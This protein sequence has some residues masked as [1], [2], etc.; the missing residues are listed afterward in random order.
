[1]KKIFK[2]ILT[3]ALVLTMIITIAPVT[4]MQ[5]V[6]AATTSSGR[7]IKNSTGWWYCNPNGSWPAN[8]WANINGK[9]YHFNSKGYMTTGWLK[10]GSKWYYLH[11]GNDGS[12]ATGWIKNGGKWY[13]LKGGNDGSMTTGWLQD[14]NKWY[15]LSGGNDGSMVANGWVKWNGKEYYL[16]GSGAMA[17][18]KWIGQWYVGTDGAWQPNKL[19]PIYGDDLTKPNMVDDK[20]KP[21]YE[22]YTRVVDD[23]TKPITKTEIRWGDDLTKPKYK[24]VPTQ[25][26]SDT[27][28]EYTYGSGSGI[29]CRDCNTIIRSDHPNVLPEFNLGTSNHYDTTGH[30][31]TSSG[32]F[33]NLI[34]I[35]KTPKMVT[36]IEH[37]QDGYEQ[38]AEQYEVITGYAQKVE[39][40]QKLVGYEQKHDGT[41]Q[42][43]IIGY[44]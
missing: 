18:D 44:K 14:G 21:I 1:M 12:M 13:H 25:V 34:P 32:Y 24:E 10:S 38:K 4:Q 27:E 2:K 33:T 9:W 16:E 17:T 43:K 11:G 22:T 41:Y 37:V 30:M 29:I 36:V 40:Y 6:Q 28:F 35:G 31:W 20:T 8:K 23:L 5:D 42:Q 15:Y 26:P 19:Q 7:W 3:L 39:S